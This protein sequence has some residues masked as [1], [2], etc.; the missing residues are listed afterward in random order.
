LAVLS[1]D[2]RADSVLSDVLPIGDRSLSVGDKLS[3]LLV[4]EL[5]RMDD[6]SVPPFHVITASSPEEFI[7]LGK[8]MDVDAFVT[9]SVTPNQIGEKEYL[10]IDLRIVSA[11]TG[12]QLWAIKDIAEV[13]DNLL[14]QSQLATDIASRIGRRLT[15]TLH[16]S[17]PPKVESYSCLVDGKVR[18][19]PDSVEGM[20]MALMCLEKARSIDPRY[21]EPVAGIALT[22]I[23]LAAQSDEERTVARVQQAL[24]ATESALQLDGLS[25]SANLAKAMLEWQIFQRYVEAE[26]L[27]E[28][29]TR[30]HPYHWQV[31]HQYGLLLL[32]TGQTHKA[33]TTLRTA[34]QLNPMSM[35]IKVD[36]ARAVWFDSNADRAIS[37]AMRYASQR[38]NHQLALGLMIDIH[39]QRKQ[40]ESAAALDSEFVR[41]QRFNQESYFQQRAKRLKQLPYGPFG[42]LMNRAILESR[43]G[44]PAED[45]WLAELAES[46]S[47]MF[48]LIL[49][50][51][52]A[53]ERMRRLDRAR[54]ELLPQF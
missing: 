20:T 34:S 37:D 28:E 42:V 7:Q 10:D 49:A 19:D 44:R 35:M 11:N 21:A 31:H 15:S 22:S 53:M 43:T 2:D 25:V 51:H 18:S 6:V 3:A 33:A 1:L 36:G 16:R 45:A 47:P 29:L 26:A 39:E 23:M 14:Q 17:E 54:N 48:P 50:A 40:Y 24:E 9:G 5:S 12:K 8:E 27:L 32:A 41:P 30:M 13:G 4:N 52:P 46:Q 38:A